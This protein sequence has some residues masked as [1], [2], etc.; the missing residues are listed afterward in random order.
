V[1][2]QIDGE[3][4]F[5]LIN[6]DNLKRLVNSPYMIVLVPKKIKYFLD[7]G[8]EWYVADSVMGPWKVDKKPP[9][10]IREL[11][12]DKAQSAADKAR[13]EVEEYEPPHVIIAIEPSELVVTQGKAEYAPIEGTNALYATN[14]END[15]LLDIDSQD[16]FVLFSGRWY[17]SKALEGPWSYVASDAL[18][19]TFSEI[20]ADSPQGHLLSFVAGTV[21]AQEAVMDNQIPQTAAVKRGPARLGIDYDG[22]PKFKKIDGTDMEYAINTSASVLKIDGRYWA[23]H[24]AVW[25][26]GPGPEGP[27]EVADSRPE[28][29]SQIPSSNPHYNTKYVEVYDSTP[30]VVYVGYTPGYVGSYAYG[31]CVV[32]G[33]GWYY[34]SWYGAH[35]YPHHA[36]WGFNM[37]YNPYSGWGVGV[38][39]SNGPF[40]ISFGSGGY[41]G[42]GYPYNYWGPRGYAYVP[43][44]VY[45]GRPVYR[46]P[47][48]WNPGDGYGGNRPGI[49]PPDSRPGRPSTQPAG[50]RDN[51]YKRPENSQRVANQATARQPSSRAGDQP[52]NVFAG[53]DGNVY[54]RE[55]D[56]NWKQ[57]QGDGWKAK[58]PSAARPGTGSTRSGLERDYSGRSRGNQRSGGYQGSRAQPRSPAAR[59]MTRP[60]GGRRRLNR[61]DPDWS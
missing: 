34:P 47:A 53:S 59:P 26:T 7:G 27:W 22:V 19:D 15:I 51:L 50:G 57:R 56:G 4:R 20:P 48:G 37:H 41:G 21:Q 52:N 10:K 9:K 5:E 58:S 32:Y 12:S 28:E 17:K 39:W 30:D 33:T 54:R 1:L 3:P 55:S 11:R 2:I 29:I 36:T 16:K 49:N 24:Q 35:Y 25:Y 40:T 43:V 42:Y 14:A 46:P 44:P 38:T 45:G 23:C 60:S 6:Q 8:I 31:G 18:P 13:S 61:S